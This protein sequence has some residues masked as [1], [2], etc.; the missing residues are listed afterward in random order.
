MLSSNMAA[1]IAM[2]INIHA[3]FYI[4]G[5][6]GFMNFSIRGYPGQSAQFDGHVGGQHDVSENTIGCVVMVMLGDGGGNDDDG[7]D[8]ILMT[9]W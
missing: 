5:H 2:A 4:I 8:N 6:K 3:S 7:N 1:S 9:W